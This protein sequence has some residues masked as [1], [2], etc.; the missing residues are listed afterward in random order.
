[1][2]RRIVHDILERT[3]KDVEADIVQHPH[4]AQS[5][6]KL[7]ELGSEVEQGQVTP[8]KPLQDTGP[9]VQ[10]W[11]TLIAG[12]S[13]NNWLDAEWLISEFYFYRRIMEAVSFFETGTRVVCEDTACYIA[14]V[15]LRPV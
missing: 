4:L 2:S 15:R 5:I 3:L 12:L 1:M 13:P 14:C 6:S 8:L 10:V 9:D 7:R 11:N